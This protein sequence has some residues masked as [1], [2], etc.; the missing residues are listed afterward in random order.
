MTLQFTVQSLQTGLFLASIDLSNKLAVA[1]NLASAS[2]GLLGSDPLILPLPNDAPPDL[3]RIIIKD[4]QGQFQ[5]RVSPGRCDFLFGQVPD[6]PEQTLGDLF[7][8][9]LE[10]LLSLANALVNDHKASFHRIGFVP[11]FLAK[12]QVSSNE[13]IRDGFERKDFFQGA[14]YI[15]IHTLHHMTLDGF[16]INRWVRVRSAR[17]ASDPSD[18]RAIT[19]EIDM[20]TNPEIHYNLDA[21]RIRLFCLR[22]R[23]LTGSTLAEYFAES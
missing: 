8:G 21:D 9:Y 14:H 20:N 17:S 5:C 16:E 11:K 23:D 10:Y 7:S 13:F 1:G 3:P 15:H 12:L 19:V 4:H 18:D 6:T 2:N 22:A